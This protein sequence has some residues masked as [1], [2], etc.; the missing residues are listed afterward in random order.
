MSKLSYSRFFIPF[1]EI[2]QDRMGVSLALNLTDSMNGPNDVGA[3]SEYDGFVVYYR[4]SQIS[5]ILIPYKI[6]F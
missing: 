2:Y 3:S 4:F 6:I 5:N 1:Y